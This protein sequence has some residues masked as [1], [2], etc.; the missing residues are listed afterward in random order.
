MRGRS[1]SGWL[2]AHQIGI[3]PVA[4]QGCGDFANDQVIHLLGGF[5]IVSREAKEVSAIIQ[6]DSAPPFYLKRPGEDR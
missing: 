6:S 2:S 3:G 5:W 4:L 1:Q